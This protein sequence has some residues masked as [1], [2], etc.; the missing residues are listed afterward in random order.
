[1][2]QKL[3]THAN[4]LA[5]KKVD[6]ITELRNELVEEANFIKTRAE[7]FRANLVENNVSKGLNG[8]LN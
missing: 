7:K 4:D 8:T 6:R 1:M 3:P 2:N 5:Q